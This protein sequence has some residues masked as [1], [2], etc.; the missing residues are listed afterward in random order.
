[1]ATD[2]P[3]LEAI[4][5]AARHK[6][7]G[8]R[9]AYLDAVCGRD[10]ELRRRVEQF[11]SAQA[12]IGSFLE[13]PAPA[14]AATVDE[15]PRREGPGTAIGPYKLLEQIG[16]GGFGVVFMA[17]QQQ[18]VRR[19]VALK[20]LKPGM[21]SKQVIARFEAERQALALMDHPH[22]AKVLD[23]STTDAGRPYFV[24]E[25][26]R[27]VPITQFCDA[28]RL[29]P[30]RRLELFVAVC[31]AVQHAHTK[32]VIHRDLKP[33]NV[34]VTLHDGT[35]VVKVI[36]FGIAKALGQSLTDKTL[37]TGF[38]Q[39]LGTPLYMSPEQAELSG[40]D[41]D[42]RSDLYSLGVLLYELLTGTTPLDQKRVRQ[43]GYD[44]LRRLIREE[45]APRPS[46][47]LSTLG[48][49]AVTVSAN[50]RSEPQQ[51]SR[52]L[53]GELDWVV[54][55]ALEKDRARRYETASA[56]A[57]DVQ[58]Y[59]HDE[60][61]E[62]CPPSAGYRFR[63][64]AR[65]HQR[66]LLT[67]A[68]IF[69]AVVL[70]AAGG[71]VLIWRV[72]QDLRQA[73]D[74]ERDIRELERRNAYSQRIALAEREW[75]ANNLSRMQQ[76]LGECPED[77]RGWE[78]HY[79]RRLRFKTL[80][81]LRHP[82][83]VLD[84]TFS[85]DG[86]RV[87]ASD[88]SGVVKVWDAHTG[89]ELFQFQA[90]KDYTNK[91]AFSPDGQYLATGGGRR[92][93]TVKLWDSQSGQFIR[94]L[95]SY[96]AQVNSLAFSPDGR[97]LASAGE[98]ATVK[99]WDTATGRETLTLRGHLHLPIATVAFSPD[100]TRR[101]SACHDGTVRVWDA[102]PVRQGEVGEEVL[103]LQGH[104]GGVRSVVFHPDGRRLVSAGDDGM[105]RVWDATPGE[106]LHT[107]GEH[108]GPIYQLA[109]S[110]RGERLA[111]GGRELVVWDATAWRQL[112]ITP[113]VGARSLAT[114]SPD[115]RYLATVGREYTVTLLDAATGEEIREF[116]GHSWFVRGLA[117]S[118]DGRTL[119]SAGLD[120]SVR[121]WDTTTGAE[122]R[123][124]ELRHPGPTGLAFS[125]DG[126][127]LALAGRDKT[128]KVWD[129]A[130]WQERRTFRD[131]TGAVE[132]VAWHPDSRRL[133]WGGTDAT[134]KV[135]DLDTG[136]ILH[137][138][139]GHTSWVQGVAF[140]PDGRWIASASLDETVK[141]WKAP[142]PPAAEPTK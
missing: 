74:R 84:A 103:T 130:T 135:G 16:E 40:L 3:D 139:R 37:F 27:G 90:H 87:A 70:T 107:L 136:E 10:A 110:S 45:E 9:A 128:V 137:T 98:D 89:R 28:H 55:K 68:V 94:T 76:L 117:F 7:A 58:R 126:R 35:P 46:T 2:P 19:K 53:R 62:A 119:A 18:P 29:T 1:M 108:I 118:P 47:R 15:P 73:L 13:A 114:F 122:I 91:V 124:L 113:E 85:P 125:P 82:N 41:V 17:E 127:H 22:I 97:L 78:W 34:L 49:A 109:F 21:D 99:L 59:L 44:E 69:L 38:A 120:S 25:L 134:V 57:A 64:F 56:F 138:W 86:R 31:R 112:F 142:A 100:G 71:G 65:R 93:R 26:V 20:V 133:A 141:L 43:V 95:T 88:R 131:P 75:A 24:M 14:L 60:A 66:R 4:F 11:L 6:P 83:A 12:E 121:L 77:L 102:T 67:A 92:D 132:S 81:P 51:L 36:D 48:P 52:L 105:V 5:F 42:T 72:N 96:Q 101:L 115:D 111:A 116:R 23:A 140:S 106:E 104:R 33:S 39:L 129:A 30:R 63:K 123:R 79:L 50:R 8:D 32:G 80:P 54:L 61:V